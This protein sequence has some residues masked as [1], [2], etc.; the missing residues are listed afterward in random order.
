MTKNIN[1][2]KILVIDN[3]AAIRRSFTDYLENRGFEVLT[4]ENGRMGLELIE[5]EQPQLALVDLRIPETNCLEVLKKS[6][7][8]A[9]D[10]PKIVLCE[11]NRAGDVVRNL[12]YGAWDYLVKPVK[13]LSILEHTVQ[14]VLEKVQLIEENRD[15]R[16]RLEKL[17]KLK[18]KQTKKP[19]PT[20]DTLQENEKQLHQSLEKESIR[21]LAGDIAHDLNNI[22]SSILGYCQLAKM[23]IDNPKEIKNHIDRIAKGGRRASE[24][25]QQILM[26]FCKSHDISHRN[27]VRKK[28]QQ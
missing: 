6:R 11:A 23:D 5:R 13:D 25:V 17:K 3:D 20:S 4:A 10:M 19:D 27:T 21:T 15:H 24:L 14:N 7:E 8:F 12:R 9:P 18:K 28:G 16:E 22:L 26:N 1:S 2:I